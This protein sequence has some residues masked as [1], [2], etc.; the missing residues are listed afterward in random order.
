MRLTC[1]ALGLLVLNLLALRSQLSHDSTHER[2][3]ILQLAKDIDKALIIQS[4]ARKLL[5]LVSAAHPPYE[6]V[7]TTAKPVY[8]GILLARCLPANNDLITFLPRGNELVYEFRR[9]L[10]VGTHGDGAVATGLEQCIVRTVELTK[11]LN[12]EDG[13]YVPIF[14]ANRSNDIA[15]TISALV[16]YEEYFVAIL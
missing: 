9:I 13:L 8:K 10:E 1:S 12:V 16:V 11:V 6:L 15:S 5:D 3:G 2:C 7:I 4:E 14:R